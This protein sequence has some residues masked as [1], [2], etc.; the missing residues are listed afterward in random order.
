MSKG[1]KAAR[2][3]KRILLTRAGQG[4]VALTRPPN[5]GAWD[6]GAGAATARNEMERLAVELRDLILPQ[7]PTELLAYLWSGLH[8]TAFAALSGGSP[9]RFD[10]SEDAA[11]FCALEYAHAVW[12]SYPKPANS[13]TTLDRADAERIVD[14]AGQLRK[15]SM[16]YAVVSSARPGELGEFGE[17][18]GLVE[19]NAKANWVSIRGHRHQVLEEEFLAYVLSPHDETLRELYGVDAA[20]IARGVQALVDATRAGL[21]NA[22]E[23]LLKESEATSQDAE[24]DSVEPMEAHR[25]RYPAGSEA[26]EKLRSSLDDIF[27]GGIC[28]ASKHSGLPAELLKDLAYVRGAAT[29]FF[30]PGPFSGTPMRALPA[31]MKPLIALDGGYYCTDPNL[32]RD[33]A[34]R[35][36]QRGALARKPSDKEPWNLRQKKMTEAAFL[37]I[38][39]TQLAGAEVLEEVYYEATP[40]QWVENDTLVLFED[41]LLQVEAKG[42]VTTL[43]S[44]ED[45]L[46]SHFRTIQ[47]LV[48]KA[49][50]Q[51]KRFLDYAAS[52]DEV[53]LYRKAAKGFEPAR[54]LRLADYRLI[55]PIG[56]TAEAYT[57]FSAMCKEL[58]TVEPI[59]G[60]WPFVSMSIDDLLV[61]RRFLRTAGELCHYLE[62]RQQVAGMRGLSL[63]DEMDHLGAYIQKNRFDLAARSQM[64]KGLTMAVWDQFSRVVDEHFMDDRWL[65][66]PPPSQKRPRVI[67]E[68]LAGLEKGRGQG[69]LAADA[70]IRNLDFEVQEWV[71]LTV[72]RL[73]KSLADVDSRNFMI[74]TPDEGAIMFWLQPADATDDDMGRSSRAHAVCLATGA[75]NVLVIH[76][77]VASEVN[78]NGGVM[79]ER[80]HAARVPPPSVLQANYAQIQAEAAHIASRGDFKASAS[81]RGD[82]KPRPNEPCWCGSGTKFK[83]CHGAPA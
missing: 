78:A 31:L 36:V 64:R 71:A 4:T 80:A 7:P 46:A 41:V 50:S 66:E 77:G 29:K 47:N 23:H 76:V 21:T 19:F 10:R 26:A 65:T 11:F 69:W 22:Y 57:P 34:F 17:Q 79:L 83:R 62:V 38:F 5:S 8:M 43:E 63:Y 15:R 1:R 16:F 55:V 74:R 67:Q 70:A 61:L 3:G 12:S 6:L 40:G 25:S 49:Y 75:P 81:R 56:L 54:T 51:T 32:F 30:A 18:T 44:P 48:L 82:K 13:A 27:R 35:A 53:T 20:A 58:P 28:N 33:W 72:E 2:G 42:G 39:R 9:A 24:L 68:L 59:L 52:R 60:K 73:G 45:S 14:I 37:D